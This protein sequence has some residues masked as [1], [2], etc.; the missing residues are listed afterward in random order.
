MKRIRC[1]GVVDVTLEDRPAGIRATAAD[2]ELDRGYRESGPLLNRLHVYD[3]LDTLRLDGQAFP[4]V[5]PRDDQ[6]RADAR[7]KL[8]ARLNQLASRLRN[9]PAELDALAEFVHGSGSAD[10]VGP[11]VQQVV[12]RLFSPDYRSSPQ[13]WDAAR[14]LGRAAGSNNPLL[15][16][17]WRISGR[18]ARARL[19]LAAPVGGDLAAVNATG[20]SLHHIVRGL[21]RMRAMYADPAQRR[22]TPQSAALRRLFAPTVMRQPVARSARWPGGRQLVMLD[23]QAAFEA[24][25][26]PDFVFLRDTWSV[27][28]A[29]RWVPAVLE[30]A[31]R[32]ANAPVPER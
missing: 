9:G 20:I 25:E 23:L 2:P 16:L 4:T 28:P 8:W 14:T 24:T 32:R 27:C 29:E 5:Q 6:S 31:W 1:P 12:G 11:L 17:W 21:Q 30:G 7:D 15:H 13:T 3:V 19:V 26:D 10:R 22:L 18:V